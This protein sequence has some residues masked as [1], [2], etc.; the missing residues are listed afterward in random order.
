M[1]RPKDM[2]SVLIAG[3]GIGGLTTALRLAKKGYRVQVV[4]KNSQAGG[5]VNR[6][7]KDGFTFDTGPSFFSMSYE[8]KQ[9]ADECG[10]ELPFRYQGVDPLYT[11]NFSHNPQTFQLYRDIHKLAAQFADVEPDFEEKMNR[12]LAKSEEIFNGTIDIVVKQNFD[13]FSDYVHKL[14]KV[15]PLL[16]PILFRSF[17]DHVSQ[18]FTSPEARQ[19]VSLVAFFL[20]RTPFD[21][22]AVY[23]LL[24]YTEFKHDG[25]FNVEGGMYKI[26]EGL[27]DELNKAGVK[28]C[29]GTE[30]CGFREAGGKSLSA[31]IDRKGKPW[32]ADY[33]VINSDAAYFRG[34]VFNRKA[35]SVKNLDKM[36]WTMGVMTMYVGVNCKLP[37]VH[38]H[39]Y[40]LGDNFKEY[41]GKVFKN[42]GTMEKPY[43]Y[44]NVI[45][46]H[47]PACAPPGA[48]ALLFVVPVPDL[49][50]KK[51]WSDKE[52]IADSILA[53]F[54]ARIGQD[55]RPSV[56]SHTIYTPEDWQQQF[57]LYRGSGLGL[58]HNMTQVGALRPRNFDEVFSNVFYVGASTVPGT[59]LPM[60]VISSKLVVERLEKREGII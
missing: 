29:Y 60:A 7:E 45:S 41:A 59:G 46:R 34:K 49:R 13:S 15:N 23:S 5:R 32:E 1:E 17:W 6:L 57:N 43:F 42:P 26:V 21:T 25:Y 19:I 51:D 18:Y 44:V 50:Y 9:F 56:V 52:L 3:A 20:G 53:D 14:T 38:L 58:A 55:I 10:I 28:I 35:F 54:S 31:L 48:E 30:I 8:F 39:N 33:F 47:N 37:Q 22:S 40:Y 4:E 16:L 24:S 27:V 11:V 2:K 36:T 12:Y